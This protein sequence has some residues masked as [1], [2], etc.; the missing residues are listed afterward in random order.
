[1]RI[2]PYY[3][4][5][6]WQSF[7]SGMAIGGMICWG[8]FLYFNGVLQ[9]KQAKMIHTQKKEISELKDE[10]K[11]WQDEFQ[12]LNKKNTD[13]MTLQEIKIRLTN[14]EKYKFDLLTVYQ[15]EEG[16]KEDITMIMAKDLETIYKSRELL[17]KAIENKV[18]KVNDKRYRLKIK[19]IF[20]Y[21][22]LSIELEIQ[23]TD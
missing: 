7:F 17:R 4:K 13:Q 2:P 20:I 16:V 9:E 15:I 3:R 8:I 18:V 23:L 6:S 10:I 11:I 12:S 5:P 22:T 1:M 19:E 14:P 21:T